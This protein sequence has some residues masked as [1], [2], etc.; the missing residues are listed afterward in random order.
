MITKLSC[1]ACG[2]NAL[3]KRRGYYECDFCG[4]RYVIDEQEHITNR[5]MTDSKLIEKYIEAARYMNQK[6]YTE[7]LKVL[8]QALELDENNTGTLVKLG[9]CY[10]SLGFSDKALNT[11]QRALEIDPEYGQ[12][13]TNTGTILLLRQDWKAAAAQYEKGLP[14]IDKSTNDYWVAYAN[15]AVAVAK[16]GDMRR[17]EAMVREAEQHGY[18]N[19]AQLRTMAG[20]SQTASAPQQAKP[21]QK[22]CYIATCVYQSY[23]CPEVWTLRRFRD[24]YLAETRWGRAFI[25]IY[26]AISPALVKQFGDKPWFRKFCKQKLDG[27]IA[28]LQLRG[29][30][31]TEYSDY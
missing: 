18:A 3:T 17:A 15:Y 29:Y 28:R 5:V 12:A 19:G 25:K 13:Y 23:D 8:V 31:S 7:E 30:E 2:A 22:G 24:H 9:R 21:A 10:R 1:E 11:Y 6:N 26:Y 27:L 16:L 14:F 20:L 4:S